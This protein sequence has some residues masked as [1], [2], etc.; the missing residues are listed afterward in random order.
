[1]D[2]Q[3]LQSSYD[4]IATEYVARIFRE[5][6]GKPID[7]QLLDDFSAR[8][9]DAGT[10]CDL[11]CG[12]GHV[13]RYLKDRGVDVFGLDLS[14][15]MVAAAAGL[16]PEICFRQ[17]DIYDL[18]LENESLA[19]IV[20]FYSLIHVPRDQIG[21]VLQEL[22]RVLLQDGLLFIAFHIGDETIRISEWWGKLVDVEFVLF[23]VDEMVEYLRTAAFDVEHTL[24][25]QPYAGVE[26]PTERAYI[27]ARKS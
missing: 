24:T 17:G 23:T 16:C 19:A 27:L 14:P 20:A 11:G 15:A 1:M 5:L 21:D 10:V 12:P 22:R 2:R 4:R 3:K 26:H 13:A 25:R 9:R 18:P 7:R 8:V 6:D